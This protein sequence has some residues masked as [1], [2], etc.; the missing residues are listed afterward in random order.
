[1]TQ[2]TKY[3]FWDKSSLETADHMDTKTWEGN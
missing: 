1:M 2:T 3:I